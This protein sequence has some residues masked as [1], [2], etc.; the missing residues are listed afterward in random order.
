MALG[1]E[2][3][4]ILTLV[5]SD[6]LRL[7]LAGAALGFAFAYWIGQLVRDRLFGVAPTDPVSFAAGVI[8][9]AIVAVLAGWAPARRAA[10]VD[11][12]QALRTE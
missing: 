4:R 1:A 8:V 6:S 7:V 10:R 11:P 12:I 9:L 5:L 3:G 2:P